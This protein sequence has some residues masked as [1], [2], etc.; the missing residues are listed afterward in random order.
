MDTMNAD[1]PEPSKP[2][3]SPNPRRG[4][5]RRAKR[6]AYERNALYGLVAEFRRNHPQ[7]TATDAWRHFSEL[8]GLS[9]VVVSYDR[10][11][12]AISYV[13]D[14]DRIGTRVVRRRS[15]DQAFYRLR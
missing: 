7:A 3:S 15:F 13:P 9:S 4:R 10:A 5:K 12:D 11:G 6:K 2:L 8:A 14:L 1:T